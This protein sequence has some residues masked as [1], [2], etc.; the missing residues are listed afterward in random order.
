[1]RFT[2][3]RL[4]KGKGIWGFWWW[5]GKIGRE[6]KEALINKCCLVMQETV[7]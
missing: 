5:G 4:N 1:L 6:G 7:F 3:L 2:H